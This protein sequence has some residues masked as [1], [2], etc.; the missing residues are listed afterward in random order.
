[1]DRPWE[2]DLIPLLISPA[3]WRTIEA[4]PDPAGD[5]AQPDP[6]RPLRPAGAAPRRPAAA[7]AGLSPTRFPAAVPRHASSRD[8][9]YLHLHAVD[10]A[11]SPDGQWWVLADRTQ[12]P[13]GAGYALENR[14]VL[15]RMLP[16]GIPRCQV[17]RLAPFFRGLAR[18]AVAVSPRQR[19]TTRSI[20]LLTPGPYNETYFE[21]AYLARY[22]GFTLVEGGDLTVRDSRVFLKTLEGLQPVDVIFRR[23]DDTFCDPLELRGDSFLGVAGLVQAAR[24]GNVAVAN[25][26]GQRPGRKPGVPARSCRR[27]AGTAGRGAAHCPRVR[28]LVVRRGRGHCST[29][30]NTSTRSWSKPAFPDACWNPV[31]GGRLSRRERETLVAAIRAQPVDFVGA[32]A[33]RALDRAGAGS[34]T[35]SEPRPVVA[36][37]LTWPPRRFFTRHARRLDA[38]LRQAGD[39]VVS[40]QRGGGSKDTWVL[41]DGPGQPRHAAPRSGATRIARPQRP[42]DLPS[43][44]GRQSLLAGP[45]RRTARSTRCG[46]CAASGAPDG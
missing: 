8:N 7:G 34:T 29:C 39:P 37:A 44:R 24:A 10:L 38:G 28:D 32:G 27:C 45:L 1:M 20:V 33:G 17:Q 25:A 2:L 9:I 13:S 5:A 19:A 6:G 15:S 41:S 12:A 11:R 21:H 22:S 46:C 36:V 31:F 30:S 40:M 18:H 23:L 26:L 14:I 43:R 16:D 42:R 4:R 3:E 35:N